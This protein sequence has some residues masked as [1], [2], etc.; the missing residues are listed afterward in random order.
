MVFA[1][2]NIIAENGS[3]LSESRMFE[4]GMIFADVDIERIES[5]RK[6]N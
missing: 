4:S 5:E 1:G 2:H 6:K 3:I